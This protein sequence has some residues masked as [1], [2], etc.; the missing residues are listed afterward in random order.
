MAMVL[1]GCFQMSLAHH[2]QL[3]NANANAQIDRSH[4]PRRALANF[5]SRIMSLTT[6]ETERAHTAGRVCLEGRGNPSDSSVVRPPCVLFS[7]RANPQPLRWMID[8]EKSADRDISGH[9]RSRSPPHAHALS[10]SS[11][12]PAWLWARTE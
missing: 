3:A 11:P 9:S 2:V 1:A 7:S 4:A 6:P 8:P 12:P 5:S 10:L